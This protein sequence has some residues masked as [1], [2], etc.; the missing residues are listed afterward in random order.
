MRA[1]LLQNKKAQTFSAFRKVCDMLR[2][3]DSMILNHDRATNKFLNY[4]L[5]EMKEK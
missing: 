4:W 2:I 3:Q 5:R 1:K